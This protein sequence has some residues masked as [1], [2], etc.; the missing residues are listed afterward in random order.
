ML[1]TDSQITHTSLKTTMNNEVSLSASNKKLVLYFFAPWCNV[2]HASIDNLQ[3]LYENNNN[4]DVIA[5]ALD[6]T[7]EEA[8][9][10][11]IAQHQLTFP[12]AYG[13][14]Q[15]KQQFKIYAYPSYYVINEENLITS[16]SIGYTTELGLYLR[17]L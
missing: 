15:I 6:Y 16:K 10:N 8:V 7:E 5:V 17:S 2:C 1:T 3:R 14:E 4:I 13:N 9:V 11:F 12:V